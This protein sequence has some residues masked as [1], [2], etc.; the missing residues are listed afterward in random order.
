MKRG[1]GLNRVT[2]AEALITPKDIHLITGVELEIAEK[3]HEYIRKALG[4]GSEDLLISQFC[5]F[6]D[7]NFKEVVAFL[8][9]VPRRI[10]Q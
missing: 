5:E 6:N 2:R 7:L 10:F 4:F 3:E 9:P 8:Y 1:E